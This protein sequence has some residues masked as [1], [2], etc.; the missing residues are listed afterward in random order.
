MIAKRIL[1]LISGFLTSI[2]K[3]SHE[4]L[5][6]KEPTKFVSKEEVKIFRYIIRS[7]F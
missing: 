5:V 1:A 7:E 2:G 3:T 4:F 6:S